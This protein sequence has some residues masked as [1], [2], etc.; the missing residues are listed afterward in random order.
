MTLCTT[1][2]SLG[3]PHYITSIDN[4]AHSRD[5]DDIDNM[6]HSRDVDDM[7]HDMTRHDNASTFVLLLKCMSSFSVAA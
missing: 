4:M 5:V 3:L 2:G 7:N 6:A 1:N